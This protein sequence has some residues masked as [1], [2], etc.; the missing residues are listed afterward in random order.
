MKSAS[1]QA[2]TYAHW[3]AET[4]LLILFCAAGLSLSSCDEH[5]QELEEKITQLQKELDH[6]QGDLESAKR[7]LNELRAQS[8]NVVTQAAT[9]AP[10]RPAPEPDFGAELPP[11]ES[12]ETSLTNSAKNLKKELQQQL[13]DFSL[14]KCTLHHVEYL[15]P[16]YPV[17]S[18]ISLSLRSRGGSSLQ[19]DVPVKADTKGRWL[20]PETND[21]VRQIETNGHQMT[22][23]Q[24]APPASTGG[25]SATSNAAGSGAPNVQQSVVIQ[26]PDQAG[27]GASR[28][29]DRT[30][31]SS[32]TQT[33]PAAPDK[34]RGPLPQSGSKIKADREVLIQF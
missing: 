21:I 11:R 25:R 3:R 4:A 22:S 12:L 6:T 32:Q 30:T 10:P 13:K 8:G 1:C 23:S 24:P 33:E 7:E 2:K 20:F 27:G 34:A 26:W 16:N 19:F 28:S 14:E 15:S 5:S 31:A 17:T 29:N 9:P 18:R